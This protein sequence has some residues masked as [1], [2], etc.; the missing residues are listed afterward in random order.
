MSFGRESTAREGGWNSSL[1]FNRAAPQR[2]RRARRRAN[3]TPAERARARLGHGAQAPL[4]PPTAAVEERV[5]TVRVPPPPVPPPPPPAAAG[6]VRVTIDRVDEIAAAEK[7]EWAAQL[8]VAKAKRVQAGRAAQSFSAL[9]RDLAR[10]ESTEDVAAAIAW[11]TGEQVAALRR[12]VLEEPTPRPPPDPFVT[13][14]AGD[15]RPPVAHGALIFERAFVRGPR[16]HEGLCSIALG[17]SAEPS[18]AALV[19]AFASK[20]KAGAW[21]SVRYVG[22]WRHE[23]APAQQ[24]AWPE[25]HALSRVAPQA[26]YVY[27][28]PPAPARPAGAPALILEFDRVEVRLPNETA[29]SF[30]S[31]AVRLVGGVT[32][33]SLLTLE[34]ARGAQVCAGLAPA[35]AMPINS[36]MRAEPRVPFAPHATNVFSR[37]DDYDVVALR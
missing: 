25:A 32:D 21:T 14:Y 36:L 34:V 12:A 4:P 19:V 15:A 20:V 31:C 11:R 33:G 18:R 24:R 17:T 28:P 3:R 9:E 2:K 1:R 5:T 35:F 10:W 37:L 13:T 8:A 22:S 16:H 27:A 26:A 30:G 7:A 6:E 23:E 29:P